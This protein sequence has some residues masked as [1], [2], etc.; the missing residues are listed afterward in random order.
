MLS[1]VIELNMKLLLRTYLK[2]LLFEVLFIKLPKLPET[3]FAEVREEDLALLLHLTLHVHHLLLR[4]GET[5]R[6]HRRQ[7]VLEDI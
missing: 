2:Q 5:K 6:F 4:G 7:K 1:E 3:Q